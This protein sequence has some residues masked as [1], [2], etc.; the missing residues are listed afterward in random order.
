[1]FLSLGSNIGDREDHLAAAVQALGAVLGELRAS[2]IYQTEPVGVTD[3]PAFL[4]LAVSGETN[5]PPRD[6]LGAVKRIEYE[7]GRR[8]TYRWG[9][10]VIDIDILLYGDLI[11]EEEDLTVPHRELQGRA[12][13]LVPLADIAAEAVH[14]AA[15]ET[16]ATLRD[17]APGL[18]TVRPYQ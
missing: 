10:R 17:R 2:P 12:F 3:Q 4:N 18:D 11:L 9:P 14:P 8:P 5:L 6:L 1:V 16:I 7:M 15:G 13:V